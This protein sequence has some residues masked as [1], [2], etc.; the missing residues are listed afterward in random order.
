MA[1]PAGV[2]F[3]VMVAQDVGMRGSEGS[4]LSKDN[5]REDEYNRES[6]DGGD[7]HG[8]QYGADL[9]DRQG[10]GNGPSLNGIADAVRAP[11]D[12]LL[13]IFERSLG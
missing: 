9:R 7:A 8:A 6:Y 10:N 4:D 13:L 12:K 3:A 5:G 11:R 2:I 1:G